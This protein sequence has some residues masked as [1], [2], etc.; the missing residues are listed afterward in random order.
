M[1]DKDSNN[2]YTHRSNKDFTIIKNNL[3]RSPELSCKAFKLL[4]IGLSHSDSWNFVKEKI[5]K[6]FKEGEYTVDQAVKE[7]KN[8]GHLHT[9]PR[10]NINSFSGHDWYWFENP[11]SE[12][13]F[14][15]FL[16]KVGF[17]DVPKTSQSENISDIRRPT[18]KKTKGEE[19]EEEEEG[20]SSSLLHGEEQEKKK[21]RER[22]SP[23]EYKELVRHRIANKNF[24]A[25]EM[26]NDERECLANRGVDLTEEEWNNACLRFIQR[27]KEIEIYPVGGY[28][29]ILIKTKAVPTISK[30]ETELTKKNYDMKKI[31]NR[32]DICEK[33]TMPLRNNEKHG[34]NTKELHIEFRDPK[35][36]Y[37]TI[38]YLENLID[39]A[40]I[41]F[42]KN[43]KQYHLLDQE[44]LGELVS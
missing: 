34:I 33:L 29:T 14:K 1:I 41:S 36:R 23:K 27:S 3:I 7:L 37:S 31:V 28:F 22:L 21:A 25:I 24:S 17:P 43:T 19:K 39:K 42:A 15:K 26:D 35:G 9:V 12:E 10:K 4:C 38:G 13:V 16:G 8:L 2:S 32:R 18:L 30:E 11:V 44:L 20:I 5:A 6:S 40:I